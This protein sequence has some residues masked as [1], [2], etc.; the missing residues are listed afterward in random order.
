MKNFFE[1][2]NIID[3]MSNEAFEK[4][5][6]LLDAYWASYGGIEETADLTEAVEFYGL[7]LEEITQWDAE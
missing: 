2:S 4:I 5:A 1:V 6:N 7:T 3:T